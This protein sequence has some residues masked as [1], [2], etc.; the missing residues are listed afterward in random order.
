MVRF[1]A[2]AALVLAV[3]AFGARP[4]PC[5]A[6][7]A[8]AEGPQGKEAPAA[9]DVSELLEDESF[10][11]VPEGKRD[12]FRSLLILE[13]KKKDISQLPPIQQFDV[14]DIM[15]SGIV[16]DDEQ[17]PRAMIRSP[18][19]MTFV[20]KKGTIVGKNEGEVIEV[21]L[22]GIRVVEKYIDFTGNET[23]KEVYIK[24]RPDEKKQK[25]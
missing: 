24:A 21:T 17:G 15:I 1:A 10:H 7:K 23:L 12:P 9:A 2:L 20:V 22:D 18:N 11:Y 4:E 14:N 8:P 3:L 19:G 25:R 13:E 6:Q 5:L 16:L